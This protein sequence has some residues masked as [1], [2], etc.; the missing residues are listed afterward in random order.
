MKSYSIRSLLIFTV[1]ASA[2]LAIARFA[3]TSYYY[4]ATVKP[5]WQSLPI[6]SRLVSLSEENDIEICM[7]LE[8]MELETSAS[9]VPATDFRGLGYAGNLAG[10]YDL[11]CDLGEY[12]IVFTGTV[13]DKHLSDEVRGQRNA[14]QTIRDALRLAPDSPMSQSELWSLRSD[15]GY[16]G[17]DV[18][19]RHF[20][21]DAKSGFVVRSGN[22]WT[23][24]LFD[25]TGN[26]SILV[27]PRS[28]SAVEMTTIAERL[29]LRIK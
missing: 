2:T 22:R 17:N 15:F 10:N 4:H 1:V 27:R 26:Y 5:A 7:D 18:S 21:S 13:W 29:V 25:A 8:R 14:F 9:L 20:E 28:K 6:S 3:Y 11:K 19:I 23:L 24:E 16:S 12:R